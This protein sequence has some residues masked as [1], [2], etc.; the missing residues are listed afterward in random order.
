MFKNFFIIFSLFL[1]LVVIPF[2]PV[3]AE[4]STCLVYFTGKG[5]PHCA[6]VDAITSSLLKKY[7]ELDIIKY[8]IYENKENIDLIVEYDKQY[9]SGLS[10]P[11]IILDKKSYLI[12]DKEIIKNIDSLI[13]RNKGNPCLLSNGETVSFSEKIAYNF[14]GNSEILTNKEI[15]IKDDKSSERINNELTLF[16]ILSLAIVDAINP[17]ALAVLFLMLITL[18]SYNPNKKLRVLLSGLSFIGAVFVMYFLYG[19][20]IIKFFQITYI[21]SS[22]GNWIYKILGLMAIVLGILNI[23]DFIKY[24]PGRIATEMPLFLRP[25]V[26]N[27]ISKVTSPLGAFAIGS[28]VTLFLLP[29]T[30][31]PYIIGAGILSKLDIV[32]TIPWLLVYNFVF[33]LPMLIIVLIVYSSLFKVNDLSNW[34]DKNI[35]YLHLISGLIIL[36]I[37]ILM[38]LGMI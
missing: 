12:G 13:I 33:V 29:C 38:I 23:R 3:Q 16:K 30:I 22:L 21:M 2:N 5:C 8:E 18:I 6:K 17:C 11:L 34:K 25:K 19:L 37:G 20:I 31:G 1:V 27:I 15:I 35:Q 9:N 36:I 14:P 26:K 4:D 10:I 7:P 28:F 24:K 32:K